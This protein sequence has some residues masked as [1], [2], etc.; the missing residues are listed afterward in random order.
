MIQGVSVMADNE[1]EAQGEYEEEELREEALK[2]VSDIE[3]PKGDSI[4]DDDAER[5]ASAIIKRAASLKA[6]KI[7]RDRFLRVELAKY[8]P[9]VDSGV[10]IAQSP[11]AAGVNPQVLDRIAADAIDLEVKKCA[12]LSFLAGIPGGIAMAGTVPADLAQYFAHV[13]RVEQKLAYLYGWSSF[14]NEDDEV[15]DETVMHLIVLMGVML[16]V[17]GAA[18][19]ITKFASQTAKVGVQKTI[20]KQALTKTIWYNPMKAVLRSIG[21][22]MNKELLSKTVSKAVPVIG[23]AV[24]AGLTYASFKPG[25]ERLRKYL[26]SLPL[27]GI[28]SSEPDGASKNI[29][30]DALDAAAPIVEGAGAAIAS[31]GKQAGSVISDGAKAA[32]GAVQEGARAAGEGIGN[33]VRGIGGFLG[34]IGKNK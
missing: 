7:D 32:G 5:F 34:S 30:D 24:S 3:L 26:R 2:A 17:G 29:V 21:V 19:A 6:V 20:Q 8:C 12:G 15:D 16:Q 28:D 1:N 23:G 9:E 14:L 18:N 27:S 11:I 31:A 33:A 4:D 25:A 22:Q 10:A 13:M